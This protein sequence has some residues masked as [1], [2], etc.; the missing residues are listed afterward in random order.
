MIWRKTCC[1]CCFFP[2]LESVYGTICNYLTRQQKS[3]CGP[4]PIISTPSVWPLHS[5]DLLTVY[6]LQQQRAGVFDGK[7]PKLNR[8]H[9]R[10]LLHP[11]TQTATHNIT[12]ICTKDKYTTRRCCINNVVERHKESLKTELRTRR[13]ILQSLFNFWT[14]WLD[15]MLWGFKLN[16]L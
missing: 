4:F 1:C 8:E 12:D 10:P 14:V 5:T 6:L 7:L 2:P 16:L 9:R 3:T 15:Q 11:E 13:K